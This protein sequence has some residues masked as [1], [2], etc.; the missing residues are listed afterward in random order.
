MKCLVSTLTALFFLLA[1]VLAWAD[2]PVQVELHYIPMGKR[3]HCQGET[4]Q[5]YT[6]DEWKELLLV[7]AK[8]YS[9][10]K[11]LKTMEESLELRKEELEVQKQVNTNLASSVELL[12]MENSRLQE[13]TDELMKE[14]AKL[15]M[16]KAGPWIVFVA[17]I[18]LATFGTGLAIGS[19]K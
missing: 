3:L 12:T 18:A 1:P 6:F 13:M 11:Q 9:M 8:L 14:N 17:G 16:P 19:R 15:K 7:D 5:C 10:E 4:F 2:E